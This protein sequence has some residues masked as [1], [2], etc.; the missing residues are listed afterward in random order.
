MKTIGKKPKK[1]VFDQDGYQVGLSD[2]NGEKLPDLKSLKAKLFHGGARTGAGRK[3]LDNQPMLLRLSPSTAL[4]LRAAA[5]RS[6][7]TLSQ[8]AE[9]K[10]ATL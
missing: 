7:K 10:L 1:P 6:G 2:L 4:R 3:K 9:E 8:V 5:K